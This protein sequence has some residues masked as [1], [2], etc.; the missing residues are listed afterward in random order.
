MSCSIVDAINK[1]DLI[2][3]GFLF[4]QSKSFTNTGIASTNRL[5]IEKQSFQR[6]TS[7]FQGERAGETADR[8]EKEYFCLDRSF[9][10]P[11][12]LKTF[13]KDRYWIIMSNLRSTFGAKKLEEVFKLIWHLFW[14]HWIRVFSKLGKFEF[15]LLQESLNNLGRIICTA[16]K[17]C[18]DFG[19][20]G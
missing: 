16:S 2:T 12:L 4:G 5:A 6:L 1:F 14:G 8:A 18:L 13:S 17:I 15:H 11:N 7:K 19:T 10:R 9:T 3:K 20:K